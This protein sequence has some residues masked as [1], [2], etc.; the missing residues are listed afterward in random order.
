MREHW[1]AHI[2]DGVLPSGGDLN[3]AAG[4]DRGYSLGKRYAKKWRQELPADFPRR[5]PDGDEPVQHDG[6]SR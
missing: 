5:A 4:K 6:D 1:D 2:S 3:E